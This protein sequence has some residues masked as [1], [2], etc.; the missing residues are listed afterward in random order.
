M[1]L[2]IIS[3]LAGCFDAQ[4]EPYPLTKELYTWDCE[5]YES[6]SEVH[7]STETCDEDVQFIVAELHLTT[8]DV[9]KTNLKTSFEGDCQWD[10]SVLLTS[11]Y[12]NMVE[13]VVVTAF[14][15]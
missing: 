13:G 2:A 9:L 12:C 11:G 1:R 3:A 8:G 14:A 6:Y 7:V 15:N 10:E 5:D 4:P